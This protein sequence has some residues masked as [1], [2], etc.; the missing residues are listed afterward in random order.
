MRAAQ[1]ANNN[2]NSS[3]SAAT[4]GVKA[5]AATNGSKPATNGARNGSNA[6]TTNRSKSTNGSKSTSTN[7]KKKA[8]CKF[9]LIDTLVAI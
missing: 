6:A 9:Y 8:K 3:K 7:P 1:E 4:I 5:T 2:A